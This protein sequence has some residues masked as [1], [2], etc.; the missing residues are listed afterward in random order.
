M[1]FGSRIVQSFF[2]YD[3]STIGPYTLP[4]KINY[5]TSSSQGNSF[6]VYRF[7]ELLNKHEDALAVFNNNNYCFCL[8]FKDCLQMVPYR[9]S[10][11]KPGASLPV[12]NFETNLP[13]PTYK[14]VGWVKTYQD[15]KAVYSWPWKLIQDIDTGDIW[16]FENKIEGEPL[17]NPP[18]SL[19]KQLIDTEHRGIYFD[20]KQ[21]KPMFID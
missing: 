1:T 13:V 16:D 5:D 10:D 20:V 8:V 3:T 21:N 6:S 2:D 12:I 4:V 15:C 11:I 7:Y 17:E 9:P 14:H 19:Y 18:L